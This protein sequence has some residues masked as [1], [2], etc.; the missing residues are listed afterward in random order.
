MEK[1]ADPSE[2]DIKNICRLVLKTID[3]DNAGAYRT[4]NVIISGTKHRP[5]QNFLVKEKM[6]SA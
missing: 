1:N 2:W 3:D 5:P 6:E 4:E